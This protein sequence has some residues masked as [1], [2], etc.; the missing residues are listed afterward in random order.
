MNWE[1]WVTHQQKRKGAQKLNSNKEVFRQPGEPEDDRKEG[2]IKDTITVWVL[3]L[4]LKETVPQVCPWA[5][6]CP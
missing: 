3:W 4:T 1:L 6:S 5:G 2:N